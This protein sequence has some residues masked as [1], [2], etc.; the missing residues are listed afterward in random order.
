M[1]PFHIH[2]AFSFDTAYYIHI[3]IYDSFLQ[4]ADN[5]PSPQQVSMGSGGVTDVERLLDG[6]V[7]FSSQNLKQIDMQE[8]FHIVKEIG[9]GGFGKVLLAKDRKTGQFV[10]F[11]NSVNIRHMRLD[12]LSPD[13][14]I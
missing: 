8:D 3:Y 10:Y 7:C 9:K 1:L 12:T 14:S 2:R 6:L 13:I 4:S 5:V 11:K